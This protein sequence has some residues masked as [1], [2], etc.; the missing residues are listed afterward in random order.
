MGI[1]HGVRPN[2]LSGPR[3]NSGGACVSLQSCRV[4]CQRTVVFRAPCWSAKCIDPGSQNDKEIGMICKRCRMPASPGSRYCTH[5]GTATLTGSSGGAN[6]SG[7][8]AG[9]AAGTVVAIVFIGFG[10]LLCLTG[11]G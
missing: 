10:A 4:N 3:P 2:T 5:C 11:V 9:M 7:A 6:V 8:F 1:Q